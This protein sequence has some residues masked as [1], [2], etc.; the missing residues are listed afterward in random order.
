MINKIYVFY[1][2][3]TC[4]CSL[5]IKSVVDNKVEKLANGLN[6]GG[7]CSY[8]EM[9][10]IWMQSQLRLNQTLE[11]ILSYLNEVKLHLT[12]LEFDCCLV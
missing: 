9:A 3:F 5:G 2:L 11:Q 4:I 12:T 7:M 1:F 10:V 6:D 8:C